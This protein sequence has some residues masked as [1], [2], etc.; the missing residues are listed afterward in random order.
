MEKGIALTFS[1][2][3]MLAV[4]VLV[5]IALVAFFMYGMRQR[6]SLEMQQAINEVCMR[7]STLGC[8][9]DAWNK[10]KN[11]KLPNN[12]TVEQYFGS[13]ILFQN[14]C[15]CSPVNTT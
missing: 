4:A 5:L 3:V 13:R 11:E 2:I 9:E 14:R 12:Q 7:F 15:G 8:N 1:T 10:T 6:E